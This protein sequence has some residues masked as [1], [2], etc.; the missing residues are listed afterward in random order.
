MSAFAAE[1]VAAEFQVVSVEQDR[2]GY[3]DDL[4]DPSTHEPT[5]AG[6]ASAIRLLAK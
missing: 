6:T 2:S 3:H 4:L 5:L 1:P